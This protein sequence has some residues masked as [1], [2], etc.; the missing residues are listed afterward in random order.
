MD[1]SFL[2]K[3]I[4]HLF[5]VEILPRVMYFERLPPAFACERFPP[6][7]EIICRLLE[8]LC[9]NDSRWEETFWFL[10]RGVKS[11][12]C[13]VIAARIRETIRNV[14]RTVRNLSL[15]C[16]AARDAMQAHTSF[17]RF[18]CFCVALEE[19]TLFSLSHASESTSD[20]WW[21]GLALLATTAETA[22]FA[23]SCANESFAC[24]EID[25]KKREEARKTAAEKLRAKHLRRVE[26]HAKE[27]RR[28]LKRALGEY[29]K[30]VAAQAANEGS[31]AKRRKR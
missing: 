26:E 30:S 31:F 18:V 5:S 19:R 9:S 4:P 8:L 15:V 7:Q 28:E 27:S 12:N 6:G 17:H 25:R 16:K 21:N 2:L 29:E 23:R 11:R 24:A 1:P 20:V 10:L 22:L 13:V 14:T 3:E